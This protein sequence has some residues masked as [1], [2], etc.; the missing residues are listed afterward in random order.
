MIDLIGN[1]QMENLFKG[2]ISIM[3]AITPKE[4]FKTDDT[5]LERLNGSEIETEKAKITKLGKY[6]FP[7][8]ET[9]LVKMFNINGMI[10]FLWKTDDGMVTINELAKERSNTSDTFRY[11]Y[12]LQT[13]EITLLFNGDYVALGREDAKNL[14]PHVEKWVK[15]NVFTDAIVFSE[16]ML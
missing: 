10:Y 16:R 6:P 3:K 1:K 7:S 12:V 13:G 14:F 9:R 4:L 5:T 11:G 15:D 8:E 2:Y